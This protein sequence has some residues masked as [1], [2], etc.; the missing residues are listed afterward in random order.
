MRI[1]TSCQA[2]N[3]GHSP[4]CIRCGAPLDAHNRDQA[5][6][7]DALAVVAEQTPRTLVDEAAAQLAD[8][9]TAAAIENCRRAVALNPR[10]VEAFAILAMA[11]EQNGDIPSALDAYETVLSLA[12]ERPVERQ[13]A[14]LLRLRLGHTTPETR[15]RRERTPFSF[16]HAA[17]W[18]REQV[19]ANPAICAGIAAFLFVFIVGSLLVASAGRARAASEMQSQYAQEVQ[20]GDQALAEQRYPEAAAHYSAAWKIIPG[21][22]AMRLRWD[23]AYQQGALYAEQQQRAME[24]AA[25]PKYIP[26]T[27][28]RNPFTPVPIGGE[29]LPPGTTPPG[30]PALTG[31]ALPVPPPTVNTT[32][33]Q[34][35]D[36]VVGTPRKLPTPTQPT[37]T[38]R[39]N[40]GNSIISPVGPQPPKGPAAPA[41][42]D[43][44]GKPPKGEITI[45]VTQA[46]PKATGTVAARPAGNDAENLRSRGEQLARDGQVSEAISSLERAASAFEE[47]SRQDPNGGA[48]QAASSCRA[49]AEVL[50]QANR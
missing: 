17:Q 13:K 25:L 20:L 18:V 7:T 35:P 22:E 3:A 30:Q 40:D 8:G 19:E 31:P 2:R 26:N 28:G 27:T 9:Q 44:S 12:P 14:A 49:R 15:P 11:F 37:W 1:C 23:Q 50:R 48:S 5:S 6:N 41:P 39:R 46:P 38:S 4:F 33:P 29:V 24:I 34:A 32:P 42:T 10:E 36:Q 47:R 43:T 16:D 45:W 21:D